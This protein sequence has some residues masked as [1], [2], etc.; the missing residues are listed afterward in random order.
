MISAHF[1][2]FA[3]LEEIIRGW[4]IELNQLD[5]GS[6]EADVTQLVTSSLLMSEFAFSRRLEQRGAIPEG[7]RTFGIPASGNLSMRWRGKDLCS[8]NLMLFPT[9]AELDCVS[10]PGFNAIGL[11]ISEPT[12]EEAAERR[13]VASVD[14]LFPDGD[15][16]WC[17]PA[18]R[19]RLRGLGKRLMDAAARDPDVLHNPWFRLSLEEHFVETL[20]LTLDS[21]RAIED[22][23]P[24]THTRQT[25]LKNALEVIAEHADEPLQITELERLSGA[26]GRTL[27]Y[28][29]Q[30]EFG[31]SPVQYLHAFRMN[32]VFRRLRQDRSPGLTVAEV[33]KTGG[34]WHMGQFAAN[35]RK[36]FGELPSKTIARTR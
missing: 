35:Y 4:D 20:L 18:P 27:R 19:R 33:A 12:L 11:S 1:D 9:G 21:S 30:E 32:R 2:D 15:T 13:G 17:A 26:S 22:Q 14:E 23:R 5:A 34:F 36:M 3:S 24:M 29:F 6:F 7:Y 31:V 16:V 8:E 10:D 28:A 25:A